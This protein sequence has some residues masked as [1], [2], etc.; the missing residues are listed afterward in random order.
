M[1]TMRH[2]MARAGLHDVLARLRCQL[3]DLR[4]PSNVLRPSQRSHSRACRGLLT[5][6]AQA[7]MQSEQAAADASV[8]D[9]LRAALASL[10]RTPVPA[11][12]TS[13]VCLCFVQGR[14]C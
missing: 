4:V 12:V 7:A 5:A 10:G 3:L 9:V 13:L 2:A 14:A 11:E 6:A 8:E 1:S